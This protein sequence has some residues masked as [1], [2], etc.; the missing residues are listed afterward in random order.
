MNNNE[1]LKLYV[2]VLEVLSKI[3]NFAKT[4]KNLQS[5]KH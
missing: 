2:E 5:R 1:N 4:T 3:G